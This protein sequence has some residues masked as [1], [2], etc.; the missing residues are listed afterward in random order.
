VSSHA[1]DTWTGL[2]IDLI[3]KFDKELA[4]QKRRESHYGTKKLA[5]HRNTQK[6]HFIIGKL[7]EEYKIITTSHTTT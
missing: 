6:Q 7:K 4:G 5:R 3:Y 2:L 1:A